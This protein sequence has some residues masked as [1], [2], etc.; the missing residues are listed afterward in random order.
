MKNK[1]HALLAVESDLKQRADNVLKEA[2]KIFSDK[3]GHF[4]SQHRTYEPLEEDGLK[5]ADEK[6]EMVTTVDDKLEYLS[7]NVAKAIDISFQKEITNTLAK[8]DFV[9]DGVTIAKD[10]PSTAFLSIEGNLKRLRDT[11]LKIPT[12]P[13]GK[14]WAKD[15][16]AGKG[17]FACDP[18]ESFKTEK[19]LDAKILYNATKEHPAQIEKFNRDVNVG[20]WTRQIRSSMWTS[21][22]KAETLD[23]IETL[24][25]GAKRGRQRAND[26]EVKKG[27]VGKEIFKYITQS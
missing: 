26:I 4:L 13:P 1:L 19:R 15:D 20:R 6:Q 12:L 9:V 5:Y 10:V 8:S 3:P 22:Q 25:R 16:G 14:V 23:R 17:V 24:I 7:K 21:S 27:N 18:E 11:Y 2:G